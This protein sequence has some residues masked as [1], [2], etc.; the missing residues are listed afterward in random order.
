MRACNARARLFSLAA[1]S[2]RRVL[3]VDR[4]TG[5]RLL[6]IDLTSAQTGVHAARRIAAARKALSPF[7]SVK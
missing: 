5:S 3:R 7:D 2:G 1:R 6:E 4:D